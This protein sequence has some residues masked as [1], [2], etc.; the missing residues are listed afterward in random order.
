MF[1]IIAYLAPAI[2]L[3]AVA[4]LCGIVCAVACTLYFRRTREYAQVERMMMFA[5]IVLSAFACG[6]AFN[7]GSD[8]AWRATMFIVFP[9]MGA[10]ILAYARVVRALAD[11]GLVD[12]RDPSEW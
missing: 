3:F 11:Q 7:L 5:V 2:L 9:L 4:A 12:M 8:I 6:I 1:E 10:G